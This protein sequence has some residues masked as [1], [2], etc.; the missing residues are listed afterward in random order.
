MLPILLSIPHG[1]TQIPKELAKRVCLSPPDQFDDSDPFTREIY[2]LGSHVAH[3]VKADIARSYIDVNRAPDDRPPGNPDGVVKTLTCHG[4]RI[5]KAGFELDVQ[6]IEL[7][8]QRHYQPYHES[9]REITATGD[10]AIGFDCHSMAATAPPLA[11]DSGQERPLFCISNRDGASCPTA[12]LEAVAQ[13]LSRAFEISRS[14]VALNK[15]FKGGYITRVH[16]AR[17][18]PWVQIEMNRSLYL[19]SRW[20]DHLSLTV[21]PT[22]IANLR[23]RLLS[24]FSD[25]DV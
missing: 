4:C 12:L 7:L 25:L 1:G 15:P 19:H 21:D 20:F 10:I 13:G 6:T 14:D 2:D 24:L 8:L 3:V 22:R 9:L 18:V 5:Y 17:P 16:G 11:R 23:Q